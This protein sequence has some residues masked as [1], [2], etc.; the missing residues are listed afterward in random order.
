VFEVRYPVRIES[1]RIAESSSGAGEHR[2]GHGVE[3]IWRCLAPIVVSAHLNRLEINPWGLRG[4]RPA[5]NTALLFK[6]A[7]EENWKT[8]S[9]L[10]GTISSGKFSNIQ[11]L[12]GDQ[13]LLRTPGGGGYGDPLDRD[14]DKVRRD[15]LDGLID[16]AGAADVYGVVMDADLASVDVQAT[17]RLREGMGD[18]AS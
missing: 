15:V 4:G 1:Y 7:S 9:E 6:R 8:A 18:A 10:F 16:A 12:P 14:P 3:R 11:L 5:D 2:G 13:I 17:A